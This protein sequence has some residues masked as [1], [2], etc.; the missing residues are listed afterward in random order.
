MTPI[1]FKKCKLRVALCT[2]I[3]RQN[4]KLSYDV[5]SIKKLAVLTVPIAAMARMFTTTMTNI[6]LPSET[7]I[8][9]I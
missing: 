6:T 4:W 8:N 3:G 9:V 5:S 2:A 1:S 7:I